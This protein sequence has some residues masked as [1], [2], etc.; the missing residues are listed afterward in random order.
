MNYGIGYYSAIIEMC[1]TGINTIHYKTQAES[2]KLNL[3]PLAQ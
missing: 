1:N 3:I 2:N